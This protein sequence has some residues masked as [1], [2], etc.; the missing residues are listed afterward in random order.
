MSRL[1]TGTQLS[2]HREK[3]SQS[4]QLTNF[5]IL[6]LEKRND[7]MTRLRIRRRGF[8]F[9][10]RVIKYSPYLRTFYEVHPASYSMGIGVL[11]PGKKTG[12]E[13][14]HLLPSSAKAKKEWSYASTLPYA[15]IAWTGTNLLFRLIYKHFKIELTFSGIFG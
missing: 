8:R 7:I 13:A 4:E 9:P 5:S 15:F 3:R 11:T 2:I 10:V 6:E 14:D 1:A 12:S